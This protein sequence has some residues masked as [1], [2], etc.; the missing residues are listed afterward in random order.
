MKGSPRSNDI[1]FF[2]STSEAG[3]RP[4]S[5]IAKLFS[6]E[7]QGFG[8]QKVNRGFVFG[9]SRGIT[10]AGNGMTGASAMAMQES[11][12]D[13]VIRNSSRYQVQSLVDGDEYHA[14]WQNT[15]Y[16]DPRSICKLSLS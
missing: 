4:K 14:L 13:E 7:G 3:G 8:S 15:P 16:F 1:Y 9:V 10:G 12:I 5:K 2:S 11:T 6:K